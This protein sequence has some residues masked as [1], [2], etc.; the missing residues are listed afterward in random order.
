MNTKTSHWPL[1]A[2]AVKKQDPEGLKEYFELKRLLA[3]GTSAARTEF[4]NRFAKWYRLNSAGLS[5]AFKD[6]YFDHLFAAKPVGQEDPYTAILLDLYKI[7]RRKGDRALQCSFVSKL[8]A[9]HDESRP[10]FDKY[11]REFFGIA[12]PSLGSV[13][14]RVAGF[15][16]NLNRIR[17]QY[18]EWSIDPEFET[19]F[20]PLYRKNPGLRECHPHRALDNLIWTIGYRGIT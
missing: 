12:V 11:V 3:I 1:F 7:R 4:R 20:E 16:A 15:V 6:R 18:G 2:R 17:E 8:V 5:D 9:I 13:E 14:F 19:V 10:I